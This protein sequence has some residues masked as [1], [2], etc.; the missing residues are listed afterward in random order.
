MR[1]EYEI[2]EQSLPW[3]VEAGEIIK[4]RIQEHT[5]I[6]QKSSH[7]DVV[8]E[9]DREIETF[10]VSK[11]SEHYPEH[12]IVGEENVGN[13]ASSSPYMWIIDPIDGTSNFI[14]RKKDFAIS[15]AFCERD[16]GIFGI[17]Y[18]VMA[19][20]LYRAHQG[21]GAFLNDVALNAARP[22]GL[23][24]NELMAIN[25]PWGS[26]E[27]MKR[28]EH[29]FKLGTQVRGVRNY[30]ATTM[31]LSDLA[32]GVLG[33]YVQYYVNSWDYGAGRV[34]LEELGYVFSDLNGNAIDR[35]YC[36]GILA[37]SESLHQQ[38]VQ[39]LKE[40]SNDLQ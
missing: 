1:G 19:G 22:D 21:S 39:S 34:I 37:A 25:A 9:V 2:Y 38:I 10:L 11:I 5:E 24:E 7:S 29:F 4:K 27:E 36:G 32:T 28:W 20:K 17:I 33:G 15:V 8:T 31:E 14:N 35:V 6:K 18:D 23:L 30:G 16:R 12:N 26:I 40:F 13:R 3:I